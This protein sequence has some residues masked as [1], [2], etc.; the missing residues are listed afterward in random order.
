MSPVVSG[1]PNM[2]LKACTPCPPA[3]LMTLSSAL[4]RMARSVLSSTAQ[5]MSTKFVRVT[6]LVSAGTPAPSRR[7]KGAFP[8]ASRYLGEMAVAR[9]AVGAHALV[10]F[11]E[12]VGDIRLAIRAGNAASTGC[13]NLLRLDKT[14]AQQWYEWQDDA[15]GVTPRG[16]YDACFFNFVAMPFRHAIHRFT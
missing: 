6:F 12:V 5:P 13:H 10:A 3:P 11:A 15:R 9:H 7:T 8:Y 14:G 16:A 1:R 4:I 2:M